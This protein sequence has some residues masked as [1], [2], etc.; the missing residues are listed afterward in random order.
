M[1]EL[2]EEVVEEPVLVLALLDLRVPKCLLL[3]L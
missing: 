2:V 1:E 3:P